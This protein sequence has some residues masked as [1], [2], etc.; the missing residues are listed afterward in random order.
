MTP[1][2]ERFLRR[3]IEL[4]K[5]GRET[6]EAPFGSLLVGPDG[7]VLAEAWNTVLGDKDISAHPELKMARW[8]AREL[9]AETAAKTTMYTSTQ[10][11]AMCAGG[12]A[13]SGLGRVV[14]AL[15][16]EQFVEL[17]GFQGFPEPRQEGPALLDEAR[18]PIDGYY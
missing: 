18:V 13:R 9:D 12:L 1:E 6:G 16:A 11:C 2:D 3:A 15:S 4:A 5:H 7:Q 8:A 10:P 14:Y 17:T